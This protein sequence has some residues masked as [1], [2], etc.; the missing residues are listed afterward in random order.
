MRSWPRVSLDL[1]DMFVFHVAFG[2][3]T[4]RIFIFYMQSLERGI[5]CHIC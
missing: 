5:L 2:M 4:D 3:L 1:D